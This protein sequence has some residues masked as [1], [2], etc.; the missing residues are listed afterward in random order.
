MRPLYFVLAFL[1]VGA[2][3]AIAQPTVFLGDQ[4]ACTN[5]TFCVPFTVDDFSNIT[6]LEFTVNYDPAVLRWDNA[7]NFNADMVTNGGLGVGNFVEDTPGKIRFTGWSTGDCSSTSNL[8]ITLTDNTKIF[9][10]CFTAIGSYGETSAIA[11][12]DEP[13]ERPQCFR[14]ATRCLNI[15]LFTENSNIS[16]CVREFITR[17]NDVSGNEGDQVCME[18][19]VEGFDNLSGI[20][21]T[22]EYDPTV[23]R[24]ESL[25]PNF[26]VPQNGLG[27]VYGL[28]PD[29]AAGPGHITVS[30]SYSVPG[31]ED[32]ATVPD[33]TEM[34]RV[35][36]T[37]IGNCETSTEVVFSNDPTRQEVNN[38]DPNNPDE[39]LAVP[40]RF[41]GG[42]VTVNEC[43]PE[44]V[45]LVVNCGPGPVNIGDLVTVQVLAGSNFVDVSELQYLMSWNDAILAFEGL[46][47]PNNLIA[48]DRVNNFNE[49]NVANGVLGMQWSFN[50]GQNLNN[51]EVIYEVQFR[52]VGLGGDAPVQILT[53]GRGVMGGSDIG[54]AP[55]N[56]V[57][58]VIQPESVGLNFDDLGVPLAGN[59]CLPVRVSNFNE[60][61]SMAF[62]VNW[63]NTLWQFT[64]IDNINPLLTGADPGDFTPIGTSSIIFD[65]ENATAVS[66]PDETV[67]FEMCFSTTPDALPGDCGE[68]IT[69]GL[70]IGEA[71]VTANSNGENV[72]I[73]TNPGDMCVLFPEGFGLTAENTNVG[74]RDTICVPFTVESFDNITA[75]DFNIVWNPQELEFVSATPVQWTGLNLM[76]PA[77]VG[78][79]NATFNGSV[80]VIPDGEVAFEVCFQAI[81]DPESCYDVEIANNPLPVVE[82]TNGDG[83][84]VI[85]NGEVCIEDQIVIETL[86]ITPT[87]C[88]GSCDGAVEITVFEWSGQGFIGTVWE[89]EPIRQNTPLM[90]DEVCEGELI[91]TIF[92]NRTGATL[93]DTIM[94]P[95]TGTAPEVTIRGE[96]IRELPCDGGL[97]SLNADDLSLDHAWFLNTTSSAP[98]GTNPSLFVNNPGFYILQGS[99]AQGCFALD[100]VQVILS[101]GVS[102]DAGED[103]ALGI[104]CTQ[105]EII[106]N[107]SGTGADNLTFMWEPIPA[108]REID[109]MTMNTPNLVVRTPG[110]Y[111]LNVT[112]PATGCTASDIVAVADDRVFPNAC[113]DPNSVSGDAALEQ[114]CE[115]ADSVFDASCSTNDGLDVTY[116]WFDPDGNEAATGL[117]FGANA[118]GTY[119][120]VVTENM[121]G[122][123]DTALATIIPNASAPMLSIDPPAAIDC[124]QDTLV[125]NATVTPDLPNLTIQWSATAGGQLRAGTESTLTPTALSAGEYQ[126]LVTNTDNNCQGSAMVTVADST[127]APLA[128]IS[129][130]PDALALTCENNSILLDGSA[131]S[132]GAHL[133]Y[134]WYVQASPDLPANNGSTDSLRVS[135]PNSYILEVSNTNTGCSSRDT[136]TVRENFESV[137]LIPNS[138]DPFVITCETDTAVLSVNVEKQQGNDFVPAIQ[139]ID[140]RIIGWTPVAGIGNY[141]PD[142]L[143]VTVNMMGIYNVEVMSLSSGCVSD[144]DFEVQIDRQ[145]PTINVSRDSLTLN[146]ANTEVSLN[147]FG[148][149]QGDDFIYRWEDSEG[150]V[151][152]TML[153]TNVML[154]GEYRLFVTD[155]TNSCTVDS[156]VVVVADTIRPIATIAPV[157]DLS[158][159]DPSRMVTVE[160]NNVPNIL[161]EWPDPL[162]N[163]P[164]ISIDQTGTF[165]ATITNTDNGCQSTASVTIG[166]DI[167]PPPINLGTLPEF[168][169]DDEA[170]EINASASGAESEFSSIRW[171]S[172]DGSPITPDA[173]NQLIASV[174]D[175]GTYQLT[176]VSAANGCSNDTIFRVGAVANPSTPMIQVNGPIEDFGCDGEAVTIDISPTGDPDQLLNVEWTSLNSGNTVTPGT[177]PLIATVDGAGSY[178][179]AITFPGALACVGT[180]TLTV[181][182][183]Q[184]T[185][186]ADAGPDLT[187]DCGEVGSLDASNS[188]QGPN[189]T[190]TWVPQG[191]S[192]PLSGD[193]DGLMP[194]ATDAGT[195]VLIVSNEN[196]GCVDT[197][198]VVTVNLILPDPADAGPDQVVCGEFAELDALAVMGTQG[199]W[200]TSGGA[201]IDFANDPASSV[202]G[203]TQG[204]NV[205]IWTLTAPDCP[206]YQS[207][208]EVII[209][210][211]TT[212]VAV[213][214]NRE[215]EQGSGAVMIDLTENDLRNG[216]SQ[217]R[218]RL[219]SEPETGTYDS[220]ALLS[221]NFVYT[222][223][224]LTISVS[225]TYEICSVDCPDLCDTAT[226]NIIVL[227]PGEGYT[228][229]NA[230]TPND[231]GM[232]DTF[233]FDVLRFNDPKEFPDNELV[234]FNRWGDIIYQAKPYNNDWNG[235]NAQGQPIAEGTYYWILRLNIGEGNIQH[236]DV[237]IIR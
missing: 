10:L 202:S 219:L 56:C 86:N 151:V 96:E 150:N 8:G 198:G 189:F 184:D 17:A 78:T 122:C 25:Q 206:Q 233:V 159:A 134:Q 221:G 230:I 175:T 77:P 190:Y 65:W 133:T 169:C 112:D 57:V 146:C 62:T 2:V 81:G 157:A 168:D 30:W 29:I 16:L 95:T 225:A 207:S 148:S 131:S 35:C 164:T 235:T 42:T 170:V 172:A 191:D 26:D 88:P 43:D 54:I 69:V 106:L 139:N 18:F 211:S 194:T 220:L 222:P 1:L 74:W 140:Y 201:T 162:P 197:S 6:S 73:L 64:G 171:T 120:L 127:V 67:I 89:T 93:T 187:L 98:V 22:V 212:P 49:D 45:Q 4:T 24:F 124:N 97:I 161:V 51:G 75:A 121:T 119:Q 234:I 92:D 100:T 145:T 213:D 173:G 155:T 7:A 90:V 59:G 149:S 116:T 104:T 103:P 46:S 216:A 167:T 205:F 118:L 188:S 186:V 214:D 84:I 76:P 71:A 37:I 94:I 132:S 160:V 236:G 224:P 102:A 111:R 53:P 226:I 50:R 192:P 141:A 80:T 126:L 174:V 110:Q 229:P 130:D 44:G 79:I 210:R 166:G 39:Q 135:D 66:L 228:V 20:Q 142:S 199:M 38:T 227:E 147:G 217:L 136:V 232:N 9:D 109:T 12:S 154:A 60:V 85:T 156:L 72:G 41:E 33:G 108:G 196:N 153:Q 83:S 13:D 68:I 123:T 28:P 113:L 52:V 209:T 143:S 163:G 114:D 179:V 34:Y 55:S 40:F 208:D 23:L 195:Y 70:P 19:T 180:D 185:P 14:N 218:V 138:L 158:C 101:E 99:N 181:N 82:T 215:V 137:R 27:S 128:R 204:Q 87:S 193:V 63:D 91:F 165:E 15:G 203:L 237:T 36:F 61:L 31:E 178:A 176:L 182:P 200:T 117:T 231:D 223:D 183:D 32:G 5:E 47:D 115:G 21:Y 105:N 152:S 48:L 3:S 129:N 107:G 11:I 125:L 177:N 58:E 144:A